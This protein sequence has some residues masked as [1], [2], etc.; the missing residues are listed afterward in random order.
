MSTTRANYFNN[1]NKNNTIIVYINN[2]NDN[3]NY[4]FQVCIL[5][6]NNKTIAAP[7]DGQFVMLCVNVRECVCVCE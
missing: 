4:K 5:Q 3:K 7:F 6:N 2:N 1:N